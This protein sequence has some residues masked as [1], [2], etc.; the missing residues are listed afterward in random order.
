M[1]LTKKQTIIAYII[2]GAILVTALVLFL[3]SL[4]TCGNKV[5]EYEL[6]E[7]ACTC[8]KDCP[9]YCPKE[10][11]CVLLSGFYFTECE[12]RE[13]GLHIAINNRI[14]RD[15]RECNFYS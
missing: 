5:C 10:E 13:D 7:N 1:R 6:R 2:I 9:G 11:E 3:L 15:I 12:L 4:R 8:P 14:S